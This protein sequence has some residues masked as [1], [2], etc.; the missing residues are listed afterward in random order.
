MLRIIRTGQPIPSWLERVEI[1]E[2]QGD[3]RLFASTT[4]V[5]VRRGDKF[6]VRPLLPGYG[7][8]MT[9]EGSC[10]SLEVCGQSARGGDGEV[11]WA[12]Q[13]VIGWGVMGFVAGVCLTWLAL[14]A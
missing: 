4:L 12:F 13:P 14:G 1:T 6:H 8:L 7:A 9:F 3:C 5:I 10:K 2:P 11:I